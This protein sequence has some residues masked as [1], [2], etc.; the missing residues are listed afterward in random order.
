MYIWYNMSNFSF[1]AWFTFLF[2]IIGCI[3]VEHRSNFNKIYEV[4]Q[5]LEQK[6][7]ENI[8]FL[9]YRLENLELEYQELQKQNLNQ[10]SHCT[11]L[12][13]TNIN[14]TDMAYN[15]SYKINTY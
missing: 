1:N 11:S 6:L 9:Q 3:F 15:K 4:N 2:I 8:E 5:Q 12:N 13:D 14:I 10:V 7:D